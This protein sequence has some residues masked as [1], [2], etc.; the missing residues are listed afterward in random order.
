MPVFENLQ[1]TT[2][3]D[4]DDLLDI[5]FE[6]ELLEA[7]QEV[8]KNGNMEA[9]NHTYDVLDNVMKKEKFKN[10]ESKP[11]VRIG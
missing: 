9:V 2:G 7:M 6:P 4:I 10:M 5:Q 8:L 1:Y 11:M 3:L